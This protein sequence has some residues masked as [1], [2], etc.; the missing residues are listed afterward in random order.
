MAKKDNFWTHK[1][2]SL[3]KSGFRIGA[4]VSVMLGALASAGLLFIIAEFFGIIEEMV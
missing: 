4:G 3:V 1:S 2:A